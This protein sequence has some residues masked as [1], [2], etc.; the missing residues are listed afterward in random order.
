MGAFFLLHVEGGCFDR[1]GMGLC[2]REKLR[3]RRNTGVRS[4]LFFLMI[5]EVY[6]PG[7]ARTAD[8]MVNSHLLYR[9]SYRGIRLYSTPFFSLGQLFCHE[10]IFPTVC[11]LRGGFLV[12]FILYGWCLDSARFSPLQFLGGWI[13]DRP[14]G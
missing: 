8:P 12:V 3:L 7:R 13:V 2:R 1:C 4:K 6:S 14:H 10:I 9:L 11:V 5:V